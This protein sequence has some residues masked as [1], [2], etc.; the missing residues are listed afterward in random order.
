MCASTPLA[1]DGDLHSGSLTQITGKGLKEI[2]KTV[3]APRFASCDLPSYAVA[4]SRS[5]QKSAADVACICPWTGSGSESGK[6]GNISRRR[7]VL[8]SNMRFPHCSNC[9][10]S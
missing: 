2:R 4:V 3:G 6:P 1:V 7:T 10:M 5:C 9:S 8:K